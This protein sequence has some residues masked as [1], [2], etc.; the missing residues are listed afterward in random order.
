MTTAAVPFELRIARQKG[1][2]TVEEYRAA[3]ARAYDQETARRAAERERAAAARRAARVLREV[4]P[5]LLAAGASVYE[6]A[7]DGRVRE[8]AHR[9]L[10]AKL[11]PGYMVG[12]RTGLAVASEVGAG[13]WLVRVLDPDARAVAAVELR[14]RWEVDYALDFLGASVEG[15]RE[16][17]DTYNP[18]PAGAAGCAPEDWR[19]AA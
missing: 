17:C 19:G 9:V 15:A 3:R 7:S 2:S 10:R 12:D 18:L 13:R 11:L 16:F 14:H 8:V 5:L 1:Y 4:E 6:R